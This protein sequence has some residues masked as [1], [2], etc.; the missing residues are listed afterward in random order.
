[1]LA[2]LFGRPGCGKCDAAAE[3]FARLGLR[4]GV[5]WFKVDMELCKREGWAGLPQKAQ[6]LCGCWAGEGPVV[7]VSV[8]EIRAMLADAQARYELCDTLPWV[9]FMGDGGVVLGY[10]E[11]MA[12]LVKALRAKG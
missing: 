4:E 7:G 8:G 2:F 11:A 6:G 10:P 12:R 1:M 3:K 9:G 5:D